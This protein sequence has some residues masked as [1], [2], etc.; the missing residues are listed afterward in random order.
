MRIKNKTNDIKEKENET[1]NDIMSKN[2]ELTK[3]KRIE[4]ASMTDYEL[5]GTRNCANILGSDNY[6]QRIGQTVDVLCASRP[7]VE[8]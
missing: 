3:K 1:A 6:K 2:S 7:Q 8:D 5:L 4:T